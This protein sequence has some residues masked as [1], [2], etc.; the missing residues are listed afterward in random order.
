MSKPD[1][2]STENK[3][4]KDTPEKKSSETDLQPGPLMQVEPG[5]QAIT[6]I[7]NPM[8]LVQTALE[9]GSD[10]ATIEK[11]MDLADR[12]EKREAE[13]AF[14][15][16]MANFKA[17]A[18]HITKDVNVSIPHKN[19]PGK[20]E[21]SHASLAQVSSKVALAMGQWGLSHHW[22]PD[23][24][25]EPGVIIVTC[26]ITHAM[27]H[28]KSTT[29]KSNI[30]GTGQ[31]NGLQQIASTITYLE[32]YTLLAAVGLSAHNAD[33][34][35]ATGGNDSQPQAE[36]FYSEELFDENFPDWKKL[37]EC[38]TKTKAQLIS[39]IGQK[40]KASEKQIEAINSIEIKAVGKKQVYFK[41]L[42]INLPI[43]D[44]RLSEEKLILELQAK[45]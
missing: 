12:Y 14:V 29:L 6:H 32:R 41:L 20:T 23:Q 19:G 45:E 28:S 10:L 1:Q 8:V 27:G 9:K 26:V 21:Y 31:K 25:T 7:V 44:Y 30:D 2:D 24:N 17:N 35:G 3:V 11:M 36:E 16:A 22:E 38:G 4:E 15:L 18:P 40:G 37:V 5:N 43:I 34:D 42:P 13:K 39:F 33:D